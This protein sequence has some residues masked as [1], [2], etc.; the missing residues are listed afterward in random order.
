MKA[1]VLFNENGKEFYCKIQK[2]LKKSVLVE[3]QYELDSLS[4]KEVQ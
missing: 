1:L 2:I 4:D 3:I